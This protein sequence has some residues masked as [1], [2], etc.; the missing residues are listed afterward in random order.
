MWEEAEFISIL[1][2]DVYAYGLFAALG[3]LMM[4]VLLFALMARQKARPGAAA[5]TLLCAL[6]CGAVGSKV[7][8]ALLSFN[9][10][11]P[12][13]GKLN[14]RVFTGGGHAMMGALPGGFIGAF[15]AA[16]LMKEQPLKY[17]DVFSV[18][19]L[20]FVF[21]ARLG[22]M[23]VEDFG[24]SRS[25]V[26]DFSARLPFAIAGEYDACFAT[27]MLEA[28]AA[29][30]LFV[31]L[32]CDMR[33][34]KKPGQTFVLF[35]LL[36]GASQIIMESLRYDRHISY[37]FI[38]MQQVL[39]VLTLTGGLLYAAKRS[40][41]GKKALLLRTGM[42]LLIT[43]I[44]LGLEFAVDRTTINRYLLYLLYVA[45]VSVPVCMGLKYRKK[46]I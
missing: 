22:E 10:D 9:V 43:G 37:T 25:L 5:L 8:F 1:G 39:T 19:A 17:L 13:L 36:F 31:V 7:V 44:G 30:I 12:L 27:W 15:L 35:L 20:A 41:M 16:K 33:R 29:L 40:G 6:I 11:V 3:A 28:A 21:F 24:V 26:Y 18:A 38:R 32:S 46:G 2:M 42:M 34:Q 14:P 23:Y 4:G 45:L